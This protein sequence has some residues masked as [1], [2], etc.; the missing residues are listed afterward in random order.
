LLKSWWKIGM[1]EEEEV[2][3]EVEV[4]ESSVG[5]RERLEG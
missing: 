1:V 2:E 4:K 3:V 5:L